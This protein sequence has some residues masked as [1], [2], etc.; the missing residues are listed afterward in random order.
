[1]G[2]PYDPVMS[3]TRASIAAFQ[4]GESHFVY[5]AYRAGG[6]RMHY[7]ADGAAHAERTFTKTE[8]MCPIP[9]CP[10]PELTTVARQIPRRQ[11][12]RHYTTKNGHAPERQFHVEAKAR[13]AEWAIAQHPAATVIMEQPTNTDRERVADVLVTFP[14][15]ERVAIEI[16]YS[17]LTVEEWT[18]RHDSYRAQDI[19]DVWLFGH[20]GAQFR[21][22]RDGDEV[23]LND[24]HQAVA[25][26]GAPVTWLNPTQGLIGYATTSLWTPGAYRKAEVLAASG[27][28]DLHYA[29]L[30]DFVLTR[31]G[32][33]STDLHQ[34]SVR[35]AR[36]LLAM[37]R[38]REEEERESQER[39]A[40]RLKEAAAAEQ[41]IADLIY[42]REKLTEGWLRSSAW[43]AELETWGGVAP[44]WYGGHPGVE[45]GVPHVMWQSAIFRRIVEPADSGA[46]L[47]RSAAIDLLLEE[48][49]DDLPSDARPVAAKM[50]TDFFRT[51]ERCGFL[52]A[53][54]R[55]GRN[56]GKPIWYRIRKRSALYA[57]PHPVP[58]ASRTTMPAQPERSPPRT[59]TNSNG[60]PLCQGCRYPLDPM[61]AGTGFH[62][63]CG[64]RSG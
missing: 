13:I 49:P 40:A 61:Y 28:A 8:L 62:P 48:F 35:T 64:P 25:A 44:E 34:L 9:N 15:G 20:V 52:H 1:M 38:A 11:H 27:D 3:H 59:P 56:R 53:P 36:H 7:L 4:Q 6:T 54:P 39:E 24:V 23:R 50:V 60:L 17:A 22:T 63:L 46:A 26:T 57:A 42:R 21:T 55:R 43:R 14:N 5:A 31:E 19:V 29:P 41:R 37:Q 12:Y 51:L 2:C 10:T 45:T 30:G 32:I 16:Q 47:H 18:R 33:S 58:Q